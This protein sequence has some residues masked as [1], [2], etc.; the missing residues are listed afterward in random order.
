MNGLWIFFHRI[1]LLL[2]FVPWLLLVT[3]LAV[4]GVFVFRFLAGRRVATRVVIF[5]WA[6]WLAWLLP[7]R[8]SVTG[9][10]HIDPKQAYVVVANHL[11]MLDIL[12]ILGWSGL[13]LRWVLKR[14]LRHLPLI[15]WGCQAMGYVFVDRSNRELAI[16]AINKATGKLEPGEGMMFFPEGTR[17][18]KGELL[19]FK[20]GAFKT[21][22]NQYM[23]VL[24]IAI[25]GTYELM[26]PGTLLPRPGRVSIHIQAP[27]STQ[28][29]NKQGSGQVAKQARQAISEVVGS[30]VDSVIDKPNNK[31]GDQDMLDQQNM[32][33]K[34]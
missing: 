11:S 29:L 22:I 15:G 6:R 7:L 23:P 9:K 3:T 33:D 30:G 13:E 18:K 17:S 24:P 21:A 26:P 5:R 2:V 12:A 16:Q 27:V 34:D 4:L 32:T 8:V 28:G 10:Q 1:W 20:M 14:E 31:T 19:P 25:K